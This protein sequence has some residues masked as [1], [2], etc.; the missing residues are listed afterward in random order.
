MDKKEEEITK[1]EISKKVKG[2]NSDKIVI[3]AIVIFC[4]VFAFAI[5][6]V[7]YYNTSLKP[8]AK[9]DGGTL[10]VSE[11]TVYYKMYAQYLMYSGYSEDDIPNE[12][13]QQ[14]ALEKILVTEAKNAGMKI[15]D[16]D[17]KEIDEMFADKDTV[18]Q[19]KSS[20][21]DLV[22]LKN[23]FYDNAII[24]SYIEKLKAEA[25]EEDIVNYIKSTY[26]EDVDMKEYVTR[27]I[28]FPTVNTSTGA[29]L[30]DE[31]VAAAKTKAEEILARALNGENFEELAK[32]NS[33]DSSAS[34]GGLYKMYSDGRTDSAYT[35]A[36][37]G[38]EIGKI[39]PTLVKSSYGYHIIKLDSINDNGRI[40]SEN[41][42]ASYI[43]KKIANITVEKN[44]S[45]NEDAL[46]KAVEAITGKKTSENEATNNEATDGNQ[47]VSN[48]TKTEE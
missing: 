19:Y 6:G 21:F 3:A 31:E 42:R 47:E 35:E 9:F 30:S 25:S 26:G 2:A 4:V 29:A 40:N 10:T 34:E 37:K 24:N 36:V 16:E 39:T 7:F 43:N 5:F 46:N 22:A 8:I 33:A 1:K 15:S 28:L 14:A 45:I 48:E 17:K 41:E 32:D 12:I 11:Y 27:H 20:G 18:E 13:A 23:I 38:L 44:L